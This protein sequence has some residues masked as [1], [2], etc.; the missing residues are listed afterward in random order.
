MENTPEIRTDRL[1]LRRFKPDDAAALLRLL[2]DEEVNRFLP[3]YPLKTLREAE[4]YLEK[5]FLS[6]YDR[7]VGFRYAVALG[8][9][10][11]P[12]GYVTMGDGE[13][14]DFGYGLLKEHWHKGIITEAAGVV[15][16]AIQKASIPFI[17]ATHDVKN[18]RSGGVMQN[19]GMTY[20]YTYLEQWQ[21]KNIPVHFRMYQLNLDGD[22]KRV[23]QGYWEKYPVHFVEEL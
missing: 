20:R 21:P 6:G 10:D 3:M 15:I 8:S 5:N 19:I 12:I 18:P 7:P 13:S 16:E 22:C 14:H 11:V 4:E 23:Y 9:D 1:I 2:S 17:T